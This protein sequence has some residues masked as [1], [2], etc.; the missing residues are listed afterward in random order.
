MRNEHSVGAGRRMHLNSLQSL[1]MTD[2]QELVS[3]CRDWVVTTPKRTMKAMAHMVLANM[4]AAMQ[5][6]KM[7][8]VIHTKAKSRELHFLRKAH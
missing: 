5:I 6:A 7:H 3:D 8:E 2:K 4:L 1:P